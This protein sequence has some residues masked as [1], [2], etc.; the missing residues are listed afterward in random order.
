MAPS[1]S[2]ESRRQDEHGVSVHDVPAGPDRQPRAD[3]VEYDRLRGDERPE[4]KAIHHGRICQSDCEPSTHHPAVAQALD[5]HPSPYQ[6]EHDAAKQHCRVET[7]RPGLPLVIDGDREQREK[8]HGNRGHKGSRPGLVASK[9]GLRKDGEGD[10]RDADTETADKSQDR[11]RVC[12]VAVKRLGQNAQPEAQSARSQ[13]PNAHEEFGPTASST[14]HA[15]QPDRGPRA[16][17]HEEQSK[18][19]THS[20]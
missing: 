15:Q 10:R 1:D 7:I 13:E 20:L 3:R 18:Q 14:R 12:S 9:N 16:D 11:A 8:G 19:P 6:R 2:L 5:A 4:R 17:D